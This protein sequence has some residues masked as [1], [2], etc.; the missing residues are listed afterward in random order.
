MA[1]TVLYRVV[2][3][4]RTKQKCKCCTEEGHPWREGASTPVQSIKEAQ[5]DMDDLYTYADSGQE[6][7]RDVRIQIAEMTAWRE[8]RGW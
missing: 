1:D 8:H 4:Q 5:R 2:Y 6:E 3:Q 7:I